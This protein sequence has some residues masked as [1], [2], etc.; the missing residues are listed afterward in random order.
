[1]TRSNQAL[2]SFGSMMNPTTF[3]TTPMA[4]AP[5][6]Y[7]SHLSC[8]R[9]SPVARRIRMTTP[10]MDATTIARPGGHVRRPRG[11]FRSTMAASGFRI[12]GEPVSSMVF[13]SMFSTTPATRITPE[14]QPSRRQR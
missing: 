4:V 11:P 3:A 8:W 1:M 2:D 13:S 14:A 12:A 7:A 5:A 6:A 9:D 10:T